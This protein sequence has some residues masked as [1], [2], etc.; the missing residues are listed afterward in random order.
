MPMTF[1]RRRRTLAVGAVAATSTL[2]LTGCGGLAEGDVTRV[3][4]Q[5]AAGDATA[6]C[7][8]LAPGTFAALMDQESTSCEEAIEQVDLGSGDV[9]EVGVWG[10]EAQARLS[11]DTLF[12]THTPGGWRVFAAAC[13]PQGQDQPYD[14]EVESA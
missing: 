6:R 14:C 1:S 11:D 5:F 4:E 7:D 13:V 12:L 9:M 8:L 10:E 3:A 2:L